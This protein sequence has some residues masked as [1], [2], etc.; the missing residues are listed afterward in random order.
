M[1]G[2]RWPKYYLSPSHREQNHSS[3]DHS[4]G[5]F[6]DS[7]SLFVIIF[8]YYIHCSYTKVRILSIHFNF[9]FPYVHFL[10]IAIIC[11]IFST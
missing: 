10:F 1:Q 5:Y 3:R 6:H 4:Q 2:P 11:P 9:Q 7:C 8:F